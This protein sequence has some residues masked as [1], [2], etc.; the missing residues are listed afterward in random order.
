MAAVNIAIIGAG[1]YGLSL[2]AHLRHRGVEFRAFGQ[3]MQF[4][5]DIAG[6]GRER[7]LKSFCFATNIYTPGNGLSFV[8][9]CEARGLEAFEPC[10]ILDFAKYGIWV[11]KQTVPEVEHLLGVRGVSRVADGFRLTLSDGESISAR[12]VIVATGLAYFASLPPI[13]ARLPEQLVRHSSMVSDYEIYRDRDVCV[14][15]AGQSALEAAALLREA[16]ARPYLLVQGSKVNWMSR[17]PQSRS[18]WQKFRSPVTGLGTGLK[19][20]FLTHFP[21]GAHSAPDAWRLLLNRRHLP[22][23]GAWWLRDRVDGKVPTCFD[24]T[25][26][27]AREKNGRI[28]L[29][30]SEPVKGERTLVFDHVIAGT[31]FEADVDRI[32]FL[33]SEL[34]ASLC[35]IERS[36]RLDRN[37]ES[38]IPGL[39][40]TGPSSVASFGPLFR[41]VIGASYTAPSLARVLAQR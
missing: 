2:A 31:G 7:Y 29:R 17:L 30:V 38:S 34:R 15:G 5:F 28:A 9:Y 16:G 20:W 11:Q 25:V 32:T 33:A 27:E 8:S 4:W 6:A 13:L 3:P 12:N 36:P 19:S 21:G 37:F 41:F 18:L 39:F 40:F 22:P 23:E 24:A 14:I 35:R 1:P 26:I 10:A